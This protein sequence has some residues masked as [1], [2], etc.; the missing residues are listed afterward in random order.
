[1]ILLLLLPP[2]LRQLLLP[3]PI[4]H[5]YYCCYYCQYYYYYFFFCGYCCYCMQQK[6]Q[7]QQQQQQQQRRRRHE[8]ILKPKVP[9]GHVGFASMG[10]VL[11]LEA[12]YPTMWVYALSPETFRVFFFG[13]LFASAP[14]SAS[15]RHICT[16]RR[17]LD[18]RQPTEKRTLKS[19]SLRFK[20]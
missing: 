6:R 15:T 11:F 14:R 12:K 20:V 19:L 4:Y 1:M 18:L 17:W 3:P 7:H 9:K 2:L 16:R 10:G 13:L 5:N 8:W